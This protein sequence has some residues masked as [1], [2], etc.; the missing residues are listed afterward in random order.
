MQIPLLDAS[1]ATQVSP[2]C[3]TCSLA[4]VAVHLTLAIAIVI[5]CPF[6]DA[7]PDGGVGCMAAPIALPLV[8]VE[9]GAA[10]R[11][12]VRDQGCAGA[13]IGMVAHPV[14]LLTRVPRDDADDW[15]TIVGVGPM[16][17][18]LVGTP[19]GRISGIAMWR[20]FFP[21]RSDTPRRPQRRCRPSPQSAPS[22]SD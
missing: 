2:E 5:P 13:P 1:E 9:L 7:V 21:R 10:G 3:R 18:P 8:G 11:H 4:G 19:A 20:A 6:A 16:P 12:V 15:G 17:S 14:A 22:R